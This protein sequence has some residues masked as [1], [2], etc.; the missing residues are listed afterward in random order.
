MS[1][2]CVVI[3]EWSNEEDYEDFAWGYKV[4]A[5]TGNPTDAENIISGRKAEVINRSVEL[6]DRCDVINIR[7]K[8]DRYYF[9]GVRLKF[10]HVYTPFDGPED[11]IYVF[12]KVS[13]TW[14]IE[15]H[16]IES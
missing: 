5:V 13:F 2:V 7:D 16:E 6:D 4:L 8:G 10:S 14:K 15:D 12:D 1:K 11:E 3:E 9:D